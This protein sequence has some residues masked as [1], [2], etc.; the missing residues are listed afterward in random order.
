MRTMAV[1]LSILVD[2]EASPYITEAVECCCLI[3]SDVR[4]R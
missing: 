4:R 1:F 2:T 3:P